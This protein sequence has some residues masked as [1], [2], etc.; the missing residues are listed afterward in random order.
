MDKEHSYTVTV[1]WSG[2]TGAGYRTY[3]RDH[4]VTTDGRPAILA[5]ADPAFL[6][7][8]G[9]WNPEDLLVGSL[10]ECHLLTYLSLCA[11]AGI[12]V[13]RYEDAATGRMTEDPGHTGHF[14]EVVLHPVVTVADSSMVE[15]ATAL[16]AEAH[17]DCFVARSVNFP[18]RHEPTTRI[19]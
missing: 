19:A 4:E 1:R 5:S 17:R 15:K 8:A 13:T 12:V 7:S 9:R 16:H 18:V 14:V 3:D 10:S 11:R 6:G 2:D